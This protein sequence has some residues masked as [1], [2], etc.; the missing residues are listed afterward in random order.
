MHFST[1]V[2]RNILRRK[3]RSLLTIA[4]IAISIMAVVALLG[5]SDGYLQATKAQYELH[6]VDMVVVRAGVADRLN[7]SLDERF[8]DRLSK[9]EGVESVN[10]VLTDRVSLGR[11]MPGG[12]MVQGLPAWSKVL[13]ALKFVEGEPFEAKSLQDADVDAPTQRS[14]LLGEQLAKN[15]NKKVGDNLNVE[16]TSFHVRGVFHS[17]NPFENNT[18]IFEL[19]DLQ[20][21]MERGEQVSEFQ[22]TVSEAARG[23]SDQMQS[24]RDEI[25][26]LRDDENRKLG[27]AAM[28][29][30]DYVASNSQLRIAQAMAWVTSAIALF[31]GFVGMVNTMFTSVMERTQE[32]GV[33]R[34]IGWKK[35]RIMTMIL[36]ESLLLSLI[37]A[38]VGSLLAL[39]LVLALSRFE[40]AQSFVV[41]A[42]PLHVMAI[43]FLLA[44]GVGI[45]G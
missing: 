12:V 24:L 10:P 34:A 5:V 3:I 9:L 27:L 17:Q 35:S 37:G 26:N 30:Q 25:E 2:Q 33:L 16:E 18:A 22:L 42:V 38:F 29:T 43:G 1:F 4:G 45:I 13:T 40:A 44:V 7:S 36:G 11:E 6:S 28:P 32:I 39:G 15:I 21:L 20:S 19:D 14:V 8:A 41:G 31:I 23:N